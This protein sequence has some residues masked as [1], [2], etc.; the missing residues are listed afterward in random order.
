MSKKFVYLLALA[1][2]LAGIVVDQ[3]GVGYLYAQEEKKP[4]WLHAH[5]LRVRKGDEPDFTKDTKKYGIEVFE[6]TNNGNLIYISETG[7]I[8]VVKK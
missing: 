7:D 3:V 1:A 4:K 8:S 2:F 6:D 5:M